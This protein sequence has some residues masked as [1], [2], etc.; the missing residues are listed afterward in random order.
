MVFELKDIDQRI[1]DLNQ[2]GYAIR[3]ISAA[4]VQYGINLSPSSVVRHLR[5][6]RQDPLNEVDNSRFNPNAGIPREQQKWYKVIEKAKEYMKEYNRIWGKK[7]SPRT[8]GY[9][10][11]DMGLITSKQ[12]NTLSNKFTI[13]RLGWTHPNGELIYPKLDL[14]CFSGEEDHSKTAGH[15]DIFE[16]TDPTPPQDWKQYTTDYIDDYEAAREQ[17]ENAGDDLYNAPGNY[18]GV[19]TK[20]RRGGL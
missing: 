1:L 19:G 7:P 15:F 6:L 9:A 3:S 13:A 8:V 20:G 10:L 5:E 17:L 18:D 12:M 14:T 11:Q 16:P 4:L 2:K